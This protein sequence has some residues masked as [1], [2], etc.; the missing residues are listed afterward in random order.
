ML[1]S[2]AEAKEDSGLPDCDLKMLENEL[3]LVK[4]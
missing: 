3:E 1:N 4:F 2:D